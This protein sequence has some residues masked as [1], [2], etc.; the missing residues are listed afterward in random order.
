MNLTKS[1]A[2]GRCAMPS[3]PR[4]VAL[5]VALL[6][7]SA[8]GLAARD[9]GE[10]LLDLRGVFG[11]QAPAHRLADH[12]ALPRR[13]VQEGALTVLASVELRGGVAHLAVGDPVAL[14]SGLVLLVA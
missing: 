12:L 1:N 9:V 8:G 5:A 13:Q 14:A 3:A 6:L 10:I 4:S 2:C 7:G 11:R